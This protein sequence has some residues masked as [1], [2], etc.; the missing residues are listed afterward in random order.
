M[1]SVEHFY[2]YLTNTL[3]DHNKFW[4]VTV[5]DSGEG[6][7]ATV[8]YGRIGT[9]GQVQ[10]YAFGFLSIAIY[11]ANGKVREK[12]GRGY[13]LQ[14]ERKDGV[15]IV[16]RPLGTSPQL[17]VKAPGNTWST[18]IPHPDTFEWSSSIPAPAPTP[19]QKSK[20]PAKKKQKEVQ[21]APPPPPEPEAKPVAPPNLRKL[22]IPKKENS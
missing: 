21:A 16:N 18:F 4:S 2:A 20:P 6:P 3:E 19:A 15:V 7:E 14:Q 9:A 13:V 17:M 11:F 5:A 1:G 10:K 22:F 12:L 8:R